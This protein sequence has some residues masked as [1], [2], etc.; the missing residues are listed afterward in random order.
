MGDNKD[1][2]A[3]D[4]FLRPAT[5]KDASLLLSWC[6]S[7]DCLKWK[8]HTSHPVSPEDHFDWLVERLADPRTKI[9]IIVKC[10]E[11]I[12]QVRLEQKANLVW[13]DIYLR[14]DARG[15][16]DA[17]V[18]LKRAMNEYAIR[19]CKSEFCAFIHV[20]NT[21]SLKLFSKNG[22]KLVKNNK[23]VVDVNWLKLCRIS[24]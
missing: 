10:G 22:F 5:I 13:T 2:K 8:K 4:L 11:S 20:N 17:S 1:Q 6:N 18:G 23:E 3:R 15:N 24:N 16:N 19:G 9:W 14:P 7:P 12:G 21:S